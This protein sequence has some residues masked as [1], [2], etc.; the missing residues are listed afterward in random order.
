MNEDGETLKK[1]KRRDKSQPYYLFGEYLDA[2]TLRE[3]R[4]EPGE[5]YYAEVRIPRLLQYPAPPKAQR[6][7]LLVCE[8]IDEDMGQVK[9]FR[10]QDLKDAEEKA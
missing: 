1:L 4:K 9:L 5:G 7:R 10:F 8:Y 2:E 6:V 3:M